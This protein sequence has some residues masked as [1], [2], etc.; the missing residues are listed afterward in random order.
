MILSSNSAHLAARAHRLGATPLP[1]LAGE[2]AYYTAPRRG[3]WVVWL[4]VGIALALVLFAICQ[5][6]P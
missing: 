4:A 5:A 3:R 6:Q 1:L 2:C